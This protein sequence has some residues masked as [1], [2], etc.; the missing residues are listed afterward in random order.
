MRAFIFTLLYLVI[1]IQGNLLGNNTLEFYNNH[2]ERPEKVYKAFEDFIAK[3]KRDYKDSE[4]RKQRFENF[5]KTY[6]KIEKLILQA[7]KAGHDTSF[8]INKFADW[9][10]KEFSNSLSHNP[11]PANNDIPFLNF[12]LLSRN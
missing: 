8:G 7:E 12:T 1:V 10:S 6:K 2:V 5:A 9:S 4:E 11:P 3:Y